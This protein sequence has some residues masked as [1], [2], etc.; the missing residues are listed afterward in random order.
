MRAL[1]GELR[2]CTLR[3]LAPSREHHRRARRRAT[4]SAAGPPPAPPRPVASGAARPGGN[5]VAQSVITYLPHRPGGGAQGPV[6]ACEA[7]SVH[8][9][10]GTPS[11]T[12]SY[13]THSIG[14]RMWPPFGPAQARA[15]MERVSSVARM[16]PD[17]PL[18]EPAAEAMCRVEECSKKSTI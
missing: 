4:A 3:L 17:W 10:L 14:P 9:A 12:L 6:S 1:P 16:R 7:L 15:R 2:P 5:H 13:P 18:A 8:P 11:A